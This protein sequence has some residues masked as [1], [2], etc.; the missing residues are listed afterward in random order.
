MNDESC[1]VP[2]GTQLTSNTILNTTNPLLSTPVQTW[3]SG[4]GYFNSTT[5]ICVCNTGYFGLG[6]EGI[7]PGGV[8]TPC[9]GNGTCDALSGHCQCDFGHAGPSCEAVVGCASETMCYAD[10]ECAQPCGARRM[11]ECTGHYDVIP[12]ENGRYATGS[13]CACADGY[14]GQYCNNTCPKVQSL[15]CG[16]LGQCNSSTGDC[17]CNPC[18]E[19]SL[20][21]L[22]FGSVCVA[23]ARPSCV[24]G[25]FQCSTESNEFECAC[26]GGRTGPLCA[27][28][29]C[30]NG[31]TCN[32]I[33]QQCQ[34]VNGFSGQ[35]CQIN[36]TRDDRCSGHGECQL[37]T[38]ACSCDDG[39]AGSDCSLVCNATTDCNGHGTC[40]LLSGKCSCFSGKA[41]DVDILFV[42]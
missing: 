8:T 2:P 15:T 18:H 1:S 20:L 7:C 30:L 4:H 25:L 33:T 40:S 11:G 42:P 19:L 10:T 38:Q 17:E 29:G 34:C 41:G 16:G 5:M 37:E 31:G 23:K 9:S 36:C 12:T 35:L 32:S 26:P 6:C 39:Y 13:T 22:Q 3:C 21:S 27:T 24:Y 14:W 28:C